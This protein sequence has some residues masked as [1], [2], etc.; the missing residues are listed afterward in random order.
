MTI[1]L[2]SL[3]QARGFTLTTVFTLGA[4]LALCLIVAA[5]ANAYLVRPLPYPAADRLYNIQYAPPNQQLPRGLSAI[6][7]SSLEDTVEHAIA[8]DLDMF[9]LLGGSY[10]ESA[11][12]AW[13]TPGY[14]Q[15][16]G[17]RAVLGRDLIAADFEPGRPPVALIGHRL[18]QSRFGGNP[19]VIGQRLTVYVSDRPN[20]PESIEIVGVTAPDFWHVNP[21]T[22]VLA[23]LRVA[24]YP[25]MLQLREGVPP[26]VVEE[27]VAALV[28]SIQPAAPRAA[29]LA[30]QSGYVAAVRPVLWAIGAA[31]ALVLVIACANVAVL[32]LV[33]SQKRERE[34]MVRLA[35]GASRAQVLRMLLAEAITLGTAAT[36]IGVSFAGLA[37]RSLVP[38][39]EGFLER[40]VPR[41]VS[42]IAF[43]P[44]LAAMAIAIGVAATLVFSLIPAIGLWRQSLP[45]HR[46]KSARWG[47]RVA[48]SIA[49]GGRGTTIPG[50]RSRM[51]S[52]LIGL[53]VA[54]SLTL[55][56]GALLMTLSAL[57][58]LAVDF[59]IRADGVTTAGI[60]LRQQSYPD[61]QT[62]A[63][64]F[65]RLID[66]L[67]DVS[68]GRT[69]AMGDWW[70]LQAPPRR[71]FQTT[72]G[73]SVQG[74]ATGVSAGYFDTLGMRIVS[75]RAFAPADRIGSEPVAV[76][77]ESLARR[78][79]PAPAGGAS[80]GAVGETL[81]ISTLPQTG[82]P[83]TIV[84][85]VVGVA[86]DVRHTHGDT[87]LLDAYVPLLQTAGRF[88]FLYF[89]I[90]TPTPSWEREV[91]EAVANLDAEVA[92]GVPRA[93]QSAIDQEHLKQRVLAW[94]LSAFA[95][96]AA[97]LALLGMYG[98]VSY[99][100]RQ[101]EKE[102]AIRIAVGADRRSVTSL[103][104][105]QGGIVLAAG[106][107]AGALG[108][109]GMGRILDSEL[110][111]VGRADPL[112]IGSAA[113][114]L[115]G[116][117]LAAIWWPARRAAATDPAALLKTE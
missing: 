29:L 88:A 55:L 43:D 32:M 65:E 45:P 70:P 103:F 40:R 24:A 89:P 27:R 11:P 19:N 35:L 59:G 14:V 54:V 106:V 37:L 71:Q 44:Q 9:Y 38:F 62:R 102:I 116:C 100:V 94:M 83:E 84:Y 76:V 67:S 15:G 41:G 111:G 115:A 2:R 109:I 79:W 77:S 114:L 105:R 49:A 21:Y 96:F 13:V 48:P 108:A 3:A 66:R 64:F 31:A 7:W 56:A 60:T 5:V 25:Y 92:L 33:R 112:V 90:A 75:G 113:V 95:A 42:A 72:S 39:I 101:R 17:V 73:I 74:G 80:S 53:E 30:F 82:P 51:R 57:R 18:W 26:E 85:R 86:A 16:F 117:G 10:P 81:R 47:P 23:P 50:G 58:M 6:D 46:A 69:V 104:V 28:R 36:I 78:L 34:V 97:L 22:E 99:A 110:Y 91:R 4:G 93:L 107:V 52:F 87:D 20:E 61:P 1:T 68:N 12:G 98:V 63:P 8:W